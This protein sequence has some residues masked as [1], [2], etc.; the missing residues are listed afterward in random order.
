MA[1]LGT[2][3]LQWVA[4]ARQVTAEATPV[5]V[6]P[7]N[8]LPITTMITVNTAIRG[9]DFVSLIATLPGV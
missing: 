1:A 5:Q 3:I 8:V 9:R 7:V 6:D 2:V 4:G